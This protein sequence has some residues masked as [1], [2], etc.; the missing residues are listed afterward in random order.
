MTFEPGQRIGDYEIVAKLGADGNGAVY[1]VQ[2]LTSR[3]REAMKILPAAQGTPEMMQ[4]L[5]TL[6]HVNIA[7]VHHAFSHEHHLVVVMELIHG[8]A[9]RDLRERMGISMRQALDY[10]EQ[11]LK[12]LGY[13]HRLGVVHGY[14]KPS[15]IMITSGGFVKLL[16]F[17]IAATGG[18]SPNYMS[19]EQ[20]SGRRATARSDIYSVGV[21]LY[22]LLSGT[23]PIKEDNQIPVRLNQLAAEVPGVVSDAVM[24][25]LARDPAERFA[26]AEDF[27]HALRLTTTSVEPGNTYIGPFPVSRM[28]SARTPISAT[29]A[30]WPAAPAASAAPQ[31]VSLDEI[32]RKLAAYIGPVA[33]F[34][35]KK[36]AAQSEDLD[37][38]YRE[39]AKEIPSEAD[40]AAFLRSRQP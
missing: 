38:I 21:T 25:A 2:H 17:G 40:R 15:N 14:I 3:H 31:I 28:A 1:E 13:A 24:R 23:L 12:A 5:T 18:G 9:V 29:D 11:T 35:V 8:E 19:P 4:A 37:F 39:A 22:E 7:H 16:D 36:L 34:V 30:S 32:S 26:T 20:I 10:M 6:N 27:L 33:K